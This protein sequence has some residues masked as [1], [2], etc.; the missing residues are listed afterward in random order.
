MT[1]SGRIVTLPDPRHGQ[2][3]RY[4][5]CP[6]AGIHEFTKFTAPRSDPKS[7]LIEN[8]DDD[9]S[10]VAAVDTKDSSSQIQIIS[11]SDL[12]VATA[13]DPL[14]LVLP[15]LAEV[16]LEK[17][18]NEKKRMFLS[19]DDHFDKLPEENSHLSEILQC[20]AT[21][22]LLESRMSAICDTVDAGDEKMFRL[23]ETKLLNIM[24]EKAKRMSE[25]GLPS[26]MEENFVRK[27]LEAP[28]LQQKS[29]MAKPAEV[30][31]AIA[32]ES[33]AESETSTPLTESG[34]SQSTVATTD[35]GSSFHS[36]PSTAATSLA[37]EGQPED[38]AVTAIQASPEVTALQRLH[39]AFDFICSRYIPPLVAEDLRKSLSEAGASVID[40][41]PLDTY[42]AELAKL[43]A[44]A[45]CR[46]LRC[47]LL[48][49]TT[50]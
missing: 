6:E 34:T 20:D 8:V 43:R 36:Q 47:Q 2:P 19:S 7:W 44:E 10:S 28:L 26:T 11:S 49:E 24:V 48:T 46:K 15:A 22:T 16:K 50:S 31:I 27:A 25:G 3:S 17:G 23:N 1:S 21:R 37:E 40:F 35:S 41:S 45:C 18:S 13:I 33:A 9:A 5:V 14:F 29:S 39:V 12:F 42:L 30:P 38:A 4:L 32:A